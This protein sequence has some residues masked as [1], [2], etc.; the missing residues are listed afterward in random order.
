[1][2]SVEFDNQSTHEIFLV[3]RGGY[4]ERISIPA[5]SKISAGNL[6]GRDW[7]IVLESGEG[8]L[9]FQGVVTW[10]EL[11]SRQFRLVITDEGLAAPP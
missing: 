1:M 3:S 10:E 8:A 6:P 9:I 7:T 5:G 4:P 2:T 11:Q